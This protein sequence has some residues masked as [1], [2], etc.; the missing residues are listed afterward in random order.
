MTA[1][2]RVFLAHYRQ[3]QSL[4][5]CAFAAGVDRITVYRWIRDDVDFANEFD[6]IS[7]DVT[8]HMLASL[9]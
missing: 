7:A 8:D 2:Q 4:A 9:G 1:E 6:L 3:G 5:I